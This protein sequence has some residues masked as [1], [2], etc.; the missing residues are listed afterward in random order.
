MD[1][2]LLKVVCKRAGYGVEVLELLG[3]GSRPECVVPI[4]M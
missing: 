1:K 3:N 2:S 4:W